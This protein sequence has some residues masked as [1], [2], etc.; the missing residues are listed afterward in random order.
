MPT[1]P[2]GA[3]D[4]AS[5]S[6]PKTTA[7][8]WSHF[9]PSYTLSDSDNIAHWDGYPPYTTSPYWTLMGAK[10]VCEGLHGR[11]L[12]IQR[13]FEHERITRFHTETLINFAQEVRADLVRVIQEWKELRRLL[14]TLDQAETDYIMGTHLLQWKSRY[15]FCLAEDLKALKRGP[16]GFLEVFN[17]RW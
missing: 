2:P 14:K 3:L 13:E 6:L 7:A 1:I 12:R 11:R 17:H 5:L 8:F 15:I 4:L 9:K 16:Q 10:R